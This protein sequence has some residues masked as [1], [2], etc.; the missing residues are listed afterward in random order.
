MKLKDVF[1]NTN[2]P[3][4]FIALSGGV[5]STAA[6]YLLKQKG[7]NIFGVTHVIWPDSK[8]CSDE[9]IKTCRQVADFLDIPYVTID[10]QDLFKRYVVDEF[11]NA[12]RNGLTP[13]PCILCNEHIRFKLMIKTFFEQYPEY[14]RED[15]KIA[16][17]HYANTEINGGFVYLKKGVDPEKDQSYMLYRLNQDQLIRC[18]FPL[19]T[20]TKNQVR[21]IAVSN[22]LPS[23]HHKESQDICFVDHHYV[24][25]L[26]SYAHIKPEKGRFVSVQGKEMGW[27]NGYIYYTRGQRRGLN[28][29]DGPW[30]VIQT[31]PETNTVII[32]RESDLFVKTFKADNV[33]WIVPP[34]NKEIRCRVQTRYHTVEHACT[35]N[36]TSETHVEVELDLPSKEATP[37]Q[38]AVFY[39][40][41][42]VL[43]GGFIV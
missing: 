31:R 14:I 36:F 17:G 35:V 42:C 8:C 7:E 34:E 23:A 22:N 21:E 25:F 15:Y 4:V 26:K 32:G 40:N 39:Q 5:D 28:L 24:S 18:I 10:C 12:Y 6:A 29:A 38:S 43:G 30:Y 33:V 27:H 3:P 37:G 19:G 13:N 11:A 1:I 20:Y 2:K 16:S 9:T 41:D